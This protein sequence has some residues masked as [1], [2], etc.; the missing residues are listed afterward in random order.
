MPTIGF[1]GCGFIALAH[2][3]CLAALRKSGLAD[4]DVVAC[5]DVD[6]ARAGRLAGFHDARVAGSLDE[7]VDAAEVVWV[8]TW[9]GAHLVA[10]ETAA[11]AGR[12]IFCE[13]PLA[14]NLDE[15]ARLAGAL[16]RVPHQVGLVLRFAPVFTRAAEMVASGAYGRVLAATMRDDQYFPNQGMYASTWRADAR[17]A[18]GGTLLEHS[19]HDVD[20]LA[21]ILGMPEHVSARVESRFGHAGIDDVAMLTLSYAGGVH[22]SLQSVWHQVLSRPSSRRL[23]IFCERALLWTDDDYLGPLHLLTTEGE[24]TIESSPPSWFEG[25]LATRLSASLY[26]VQARAFLDAVQS[27]ARPFPD[28]RVALDAHRVVDAA[29]R[30]SSADGAP[31][32]L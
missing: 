18:G 32:S 15:A 2:S 24:Q 13:K 20:V 28:A 17:L 14:P 27:G 8:C 23:E 22:A 12:A 7:V 29:Y 19:I 11:S 3:F 9:T 10:V 21:S 26:A 30:S 4:A 25:R 31:V 6:P 16:E 1:V 5:Y